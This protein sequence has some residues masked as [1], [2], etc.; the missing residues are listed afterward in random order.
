MKTIS[1]DIHHMILAAQLRLR[2]I[3]PPQLSFSYDSEIFNFEADL[4]LF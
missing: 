2:S 3:S 1:E 4:L